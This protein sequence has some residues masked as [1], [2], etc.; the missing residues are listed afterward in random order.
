MI[1]IC[2]HPIIE[3]KQREN[4]L[5]KNET[6]MLSNVVNTLRNSILGGGGDDEIVE[7]NWAGKTL[8]FRKNKL[9]EWHA[10][11]TA[12]QKLDWI[13]SHPE[14]RDE[15]VAVHREKGFSAGGTMNPDELVL[16]SWSGKK[17]LLERA[18]LEDWYNSSYES[19]VDYVHKNRDA[20]LD[21]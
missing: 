10:A 14:A 21:K 4:Y 16:I 8:H 15:D 19:H 17:L 11:K 12:D 6:K 13:N 20:V 7:V 18:Q 9:D 1:R 2:S 5:Q 3:Q